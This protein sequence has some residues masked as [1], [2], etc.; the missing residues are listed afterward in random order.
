MNSRP[1]ASKW[2]D[3]LVSRQS[4]PTLTPMV[5]HAEISP[6][7][8]MQVYHNVAKWI[9]RYSLQPNTVHRSDHTAWV[10][11]LICRCKSTVDIVQNTPT[12]YFELDECC[13]RAAATKEVCQLLQDSSVP[14]RLSFFFSTTFLLFFSN[15]LRNKTGFGM[16]ATSRLRWSSLLSL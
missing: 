4:R 10:L 13:D 14:S 15:F 5:P 16:Q 1:S 3:T 8:A 9:K 6:Q 7:R 2:T 12:V 11:S